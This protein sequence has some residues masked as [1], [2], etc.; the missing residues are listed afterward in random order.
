[1]II[2]RPDVRSFHGRHARSIN[3]RA[4]PSGPARLT[5]ISAVDGKQVQFQGKAQL[6]APRRNALRKRFC[7]LPKK[8]AQTVDPI[9]KALRTPRQAA[10][11]TEALFAKVSAE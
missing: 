9:T 5:R 7:Q 2:S 6:R 8:S 11:V 10:E 1:V 3:V 4:R